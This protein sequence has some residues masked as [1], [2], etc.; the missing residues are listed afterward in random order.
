MPLE[1]LGAAILEGETGAGDQVLVISERDP[2]E[3]R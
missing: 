2:S 3:R 1:L